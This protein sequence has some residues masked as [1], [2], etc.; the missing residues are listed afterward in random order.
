MDCFS[1]EPNTDTNEQSNGHFILNPLSHRKR[2][3]RVRVRGG[4]IV[5]LIAT[6]YEN[7]KKAPVTG[8]H[9]GPSLGLSNY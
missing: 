3:E 9:W 4:L 6:W 2:G 1:R 5:T 7:H 8:N